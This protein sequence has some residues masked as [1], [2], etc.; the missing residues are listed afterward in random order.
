ME[1]QKLPNEIAIIVLS[2]FGIICCW[3]FGLGII[4]AVI[5][6]VLA[7]KSQRIYKEKPELYSNFKTINIG[8]IL[9][10]IGIVLSVYYIGS[11]IYQIS[12]IGWDGIMEQQREMMEQWG[13]EE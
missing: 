12:T 1:Q 9:A 4:P 13:I 3:C 11:V 2:I 7:L 10:I 8:K 5:A 6:L